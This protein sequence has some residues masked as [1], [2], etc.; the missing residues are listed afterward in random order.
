M[1]GSSVMA[2]LHSSLH[3]LGWIF[4]TGDR[5]QVMP[6]EVSTWSKRS[7]KYFFIIAWWKQENRQVWKYET[8]LKKFAD[9]W[10]MRVCSYQT[11]FLNT[12]YFCHLLKTPIETKWLFCR[13]SFWNKCLNSVGSLYSVPK[14]LAIALSHLFCFK[15]N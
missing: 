1:E 3:G 4:P 11:L 15:L 9:Q 10:K 5:F 7:K 14:T 2:P 13:I 12:F 8:N 6:V